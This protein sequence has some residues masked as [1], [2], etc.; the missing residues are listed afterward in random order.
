M[1]QKPLRVDAL[2]YVL[3][4]GHIERI[5][6]DVDRMP[7][8]EYPEAFMPPSAAAVPN[9]FRALDMVRPD[10]SR[11]ERRKTRVLILPSSQYSLQCLN[12]CLA[13]VHLMSH[14]VFGDSPDQHVTVIEPGS[15]ERTLREKDEKTECETAPGA[16]HRYT[17]KH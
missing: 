14:D 7:G 9:V 6:G 3:R 15:A 10:G 5:E 2:V 17:L 1:L 16:C 13:A 8:V 12:S 4:K 11:H